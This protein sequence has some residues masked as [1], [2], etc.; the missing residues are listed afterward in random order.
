[1]WGWWRGENH[2][3][4]KHRRKDETGTD[5]LK[6]AVR[7]ND[8]EM[9]QDILANDADEFSLDDMIDMLILNSKTYKSV[10]IEK[11]LFQFCRRFD[12]QLEGVI[13]FEQNDKRLEWLLK[14]NES[15]QNM[16]NDCSDEDSNQHESEMNYQLDVAQ[17]DFMI[18]EDLPNDVVTTSTDL[19]S[20]SFQPAQQNVASGYPNS[21]QDCIERFGVYG[22]YYI[23]MLRDQA[24]AQFQSGQIS[25]DWI[26][27]PLKAEVLDQVLPQFSTYHSRIADQMSDDSDSRKRKISETDCD[28]VWNTDKDHSKDKEKRLKIDGE[29]KEHKKGTK[30]KRD[31]E[32]HYSNSD[33]FR[34]PPP[35][36]F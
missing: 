17:T 18:E 24:S 5:R 2:S 6:T 31:E 25:E 32:T 8:L 36:R 28:K 27:N 11:D 16:T 20:S 7:S 21:I 15:C 30:R 9:I 35:N 3:N 13:E 1:M 14:L 4:Q 22:M 23:L 33:F 26:S 12:Q 10:D 34:M 29:Y 19:S